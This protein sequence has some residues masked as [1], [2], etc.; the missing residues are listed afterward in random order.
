MA[1]AYVS[2]AIVS[3]C[4]VLLCRT[5]FCSESSSAHSMMTLLTSKHW[6]RWRKSRPAIVCGSSLAAGTENGTETLPRG[7]ETERPIGG[8]GVY[9]SAARASA[10]SAPFDEI[11]IRKSWRQHSI[12][13]SKIGTRLRRHTASGAWTTGCGAP[14]G[15][16][17]SAASRK[18]KTTSD[19]SCS[20]HTMHAPYI[21]DLSAAVSTNDVT[22][23]IA[24]TAASSGVTSRTPCGKQNIATSGANF[25]PAPGRSSVGMRSSTVGSKSVVSSAM[26]DLS[27]DDFEMYAP[28]FEPSA[29]ERCSRTP[30][31]Q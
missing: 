20:Y 3:T 7:S 28:L 6:K 27:A 31:S 4:G 16:S 24:C 29:G 13:A 17:A 25:I 10:E 18:A 1:A 5:T 21:R 2:A 22:T 19:G 26:F 14:S 12:S 9:S 30:T 23:G 11:R 15:G 8:S